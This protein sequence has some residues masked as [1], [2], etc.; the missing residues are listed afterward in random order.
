M[1]S[2]RHIH[3]ADIHAQLRHLGPG[4]YELELAEAWIAADA[5]FTSVEQVEA[6]CPPD[7][8]QLSCI[9]EKAK[10]VL[11]VKEQDHG[12]LVL[13]RRRRKACVDFI[14]AELPPPPP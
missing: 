13:E 6:A 9:V 1:Q 10:R 11:D 8:K 7:E 4:A 3:G 14:D 12:D 5:L 2:A